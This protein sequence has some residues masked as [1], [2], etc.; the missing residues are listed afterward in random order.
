[1][2]VTRWGRGDVTAVHSSAVAVA[3]A[4]RLD[5]LVGRRRETTESPLAR[6]LLETWPVAMMHFRQ[7]M[8]SEQ[9]TAVAMK[10]AQVYGD[11]SQIDARR[12][13]GM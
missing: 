8:P 6:R 10:Q 11:C 9:A 13:S 7:V 12:F 3:A 1:M 4:S 2:L 5:A